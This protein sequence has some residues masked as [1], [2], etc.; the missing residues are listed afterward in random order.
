MRSIFVV[1]A[2]SRPAFNAALASEA[3]GLALDLSSTAESEIEAARKN[4]AAWI[5]EAREKNKVCLAQIH[6]L[7]S[8]FADGD[9]DAV[10]GARP[11]GIVLPDACGGRDVQ[12]LGAKLAVREAENGLPDG[13]GKILVLAADSPAAIFELGSFARATRRLIGIGRNEALLMRRLGI[14]AFPGTRPEPLAVARALCLFA[15]AAAHAPAY[16]CAEP[17]EGEDFSRACAQ[18]ARENFA[19]KFVLS[20]AQANIVNTAFAKGALP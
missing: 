12:H 13:F 17:G 10:M 11:D 4:V 18:A 3:D 6:A 9:L 14:A 15:A 16:D 7:A 19:G 8:N 20:A 5:A 1:S 2:V